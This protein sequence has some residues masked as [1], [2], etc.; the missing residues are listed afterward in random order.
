MPS[1]PATDIPK[2]AALTGNSVWLR[3]IFWA[4]LVPSSL[5]VALYLLNPRAAIVETGIDGDDALF[6]VRYAHNFL[7]TG[8]F[9]W[10]AGERPDFGGTSQLYLWLTT[11]VQAFLKDGDPSSVIVLSLLGGLLTTIAL[12][13]LLRREAIDFDRQA[14]SGPDAAAAT[15]LLIF[16]GIAVIALNPKFYEQWHVGL[17]TTW[18]MFL[19]ALYIL[20]LPRFL[21]SRRLFW[22]ALPM[23][24]VVLF[25]Q[26]PDLGLIGTMPLM[27]GLVLGRERKRTDFLIAGLITAA[28]LVLTLL[29]WNR[30]YG[31]PVPLPSMVKTAFSR[32][33]AHN[34]DA[35]YAYANRHELLL[36]LRENLVALAY[37]IFYFAFF[38]KHS[39]RSLSVS[40]ISL[41]MAALAY[42][43]F[44][45]FGNKY[46]ITVGG[47]RFFMP[48]VPILL[49]FAIRGFALALRS[50]MAKNRTVSRAGLRSPAIYRVGAVAIAAVIVIQLPLLLKDVLLPA[51]HEARSI[52]AP[53]IRAAVLGQMRVSGKWDA[54]I[55]ELGNPAYDHCS[56]AD[57]ELGGIGLMPVTRNVYDLSGLNNTDLIVHRESAP[58]YL[59][60]KLPGYIWYRRVDFYWGLKLEDDPQFRAVYDFHPQSG[61]ATLRGSGCVIGSATP[62]SGVP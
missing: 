62:L 41:G 27:A 48:T 2:K 40:D 59:L 9:S 6:F 61:I 23:A 10:I 5:I 28:L 14:A 13:L 21:A 8:K 54:A 56:A 16:F 12:L 31:F 19:V 38:R 52:H 49:Y 39:R 11:C 22:A 35:L 3:S 18:S 47:A 20:L 46:P 43:L 4:G 30:Y 60:R 37:G 51:W 53:T 33:S 42:V 32:Y 7:T 34:V 26:R 15:R 36:Y 45:T 57:T 1:L 44:Q 24:A 25:W 55:A 17:E 58:H 50:W 29:A